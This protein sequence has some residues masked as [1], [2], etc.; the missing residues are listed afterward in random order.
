MRLRSIAVAGILLLAGS[1]CARSPDPAGATCLH[2]LRRRLPEARV[3]AVK[4]ERGSRAAVEFELG[5]DRH[6]GRLACTVEASGSGG[7]WRVR[8]AS[9]DGVDLTDAE[10]AVVN[11]DLFLYDL[12]RAGSP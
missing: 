9:V 1:S 11:A 6:A 7:G 8:S 10:L 4:A 12:A 3:V 2:V 5:E